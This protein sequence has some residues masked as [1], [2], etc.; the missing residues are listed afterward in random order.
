MFEHTQNGKGLLRCLETSFVNH[1]SPVLDNIKS[2]QSSLC[3]A[4]H[5][6][7]VAAFQNVFLKQMSTDRISKPLKAACNLNQRDQ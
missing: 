5:S 7:S 4:L 6:H 1:L 3:C 2:Y